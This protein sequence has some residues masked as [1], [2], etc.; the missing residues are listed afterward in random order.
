MSI[1][2][3]QRLACV[4]RILDLVHGV[5][6]SDFFI[7]FTDFEMSLEDSGVPLRNGKQQGRS[8]LLFIAPGAFCL[9]PT[10]GFP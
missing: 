5:L 9:Q 2:F 3:S 4:S 7:D 1:Y 10:G 6:Y 8:S